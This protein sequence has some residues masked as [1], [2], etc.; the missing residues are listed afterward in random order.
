MAYSI[1]AVKA[2][3]LLLTLGALASCGMN[4]VNGSVSVPA[5][6][7]SGDVGTVNGSVSVGEGATVGQAMTVN[8]GVRLDA[9]AVAKSVKT[10]NGE[11]TLGDSVKVSEG[12]FTV[13]G[14]LRLENSAEVTGGIGN[15]NG[16]IRL[17]S[18]HVGGG[19]ATVNGDIDVGSGSRVEG[20]IH[21]GKADYSNNANARLPRIVIGPNATVTGT[22]NFERPVKL[23]VSE[24]ATVSGP[25][26][27][28]T[29][30]AFA[31]DQPPTET[32]A[33]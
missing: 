15:V 5:G 22:L 11:I 4:S 16:D 29:P 27:G 14:A 1:T 28:A 25:I 31:G 21:V 3:A 23:Y 10:V 20:G 8:G 26:Q 13:N 33:N 19:I 2:T 18:A 30:E 7:Q 32:A 12:V 6:S 17:A 9:R 24:S